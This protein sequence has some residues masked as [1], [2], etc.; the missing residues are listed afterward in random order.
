[1]KKNEYEILEILNSLGSKKLDL[2]ILFSFYSLDLSFEIRNII[3]E[4]IGMHEEKGFILLEKMINRF[5]LKPELINAIK[6]TNFKEARDFLIKNIYQYNKLNIH[7]IKALEPWGGD[8]EV[9]LIREIFAVN[10]T[11]FSIAG[12]N[13]LHFKAYKLSDE[14]LLSLINQI[15]TVRNFIINFKIITI[16]KRRGSQKVC[17][18]LHDFALNEEFEIAKYAIVSLGSIWNE[19][20]F[21][22][23]SSLEREIS[24]TSLLTCVHNQKL[25]SSQFK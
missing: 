9:K 19:N 24:N 18:S 22:Q 16:L 2:E 13:I 23:L 10:E 5:G 7:V 1:M 8:L 4:K 3:A 17:R 12:L 15:Q 20:S 6:L 25:I 21:E 11:E 14:I